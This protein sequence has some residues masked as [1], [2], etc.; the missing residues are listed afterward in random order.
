[1]QKK[2]INSVLIVLTLFVWG[3]VFFKFFGHKNPE[4]EYTEYNKMS[5]VD[6]SK[7]TSKDTFY[8]KIESNPFKLKKKSIVQTP[9]KTIT[10]VSKKNQ[11]PKNVSWPKITYHGFIK[12]SSNTTK[13][14]LL[15]ID[16]K[17]YRTRELETIDDLKIVKAFSDSII[18][19]L[20]NQEKTILK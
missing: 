3:S 17:V 14:A 2:V 7:K 13:L 1:M 19:S 15:K 6:Y 5:I 20:N 4:I 10:T 12:S 16:N 8:L 9:K 11:T 18:V